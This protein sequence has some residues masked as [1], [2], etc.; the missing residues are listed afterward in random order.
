MFKR[1]PIAWCHCRIQ[2]L[3]DD[4]C[5]L[6]N[7]DIL[8]KRVE[9]KSR[10]KYTLLFSAQTSYCPDP[11]PFSWNI[12]TPVKKG[13]MLNTSATYSRDIIHIWPWT[14]V[15]KPVFSRPV[16]SIVYFL[17]SYKTFT[18]VKYMVA[19]DTACEFWRYIFLLYLL[20]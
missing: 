12:N 15:E 2:F 4:V 6:P 7:T 20:L 3:T 8:N 9:K 17:Y 16:R 14:L 1:H 10:G 18:A 5:I 11:P 19:I 13:I